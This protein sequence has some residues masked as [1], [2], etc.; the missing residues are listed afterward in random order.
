M[1]QSTIPFQPAPVADESP[2]PEL[3][4]STGNRKAVLA[5]LGLA[6]VALLGLAAFFL[7]FAGGSDPAA[8][9]SPA[10]PKAPQ[11]TASPSPAATTS[12]VPA[13]SGRRAGNDP[14]QPLIVEAAPAAAAADSAA[15]GGATNTDPTGTTGSTSADASLPGSTTGGSTGSTTDSSGTTTEPQASAAYRFRVVSVNADNSRVTVKVDDKVY[16]D[17]KA[18]EVFAKYFKVLGISGS[19]SYFQFGDEKFTVLGKKAITIAG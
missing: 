14:F 19:S 4:E 15:A 6:G 8:D 16:R 17:L 18:G 3:A 2:A 7:F 10:A 11:A 1:S 5:L 12:A 13:A 9:A